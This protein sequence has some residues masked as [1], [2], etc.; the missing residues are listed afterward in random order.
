MKKHPY[1][2]NLYVSDTGQVWFYANKYKI[3]HSDKT[4]RAYYPACHLLKE[5]T[6]KY[7][8]IYYTIPE[9]IGWKHKKKKYMVKSM[10]KLQRPVER[11]RL[12]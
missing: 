8:Y 5:S 12:K 3:K 4:Q 9:H 7:G 1:I 11:R 6:D 2:D 10:G